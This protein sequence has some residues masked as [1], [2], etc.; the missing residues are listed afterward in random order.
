VSNLDFAFGNLF[1]YS[2]LGYFEGLKIAR[3]CT[4][5]HSQSGFNIDLKLGARLARATKKKHVVTV[6]QQIGS[7]HEDVQLTSKLLD[8]LLA[9]DHVVVNRRSSFK[10]LMDNGVGKIT[11]LYNPIPVEDFK[12]PE[13]MRSISPSKPRETVRCL[14]IGR[15][16]KRRGPELAL[17]GFENALGSGVDAELWIVGGGDLET[18]LRSYVSSRGLADSVKFFGDQSD[19]RGFLWNSDIFLATSEI[20]NSPSLALREAMASE[21]AI[22]ATDVEDTNTIIDKDETGL[23]VQPNEQSIGSAIEK[24]ASEEGIRKRLGIAAA[25]LVERKFDI[26]PYVEDLLRVYKKTLQG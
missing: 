8:L 9:A 11:L 14:Y 21:L 17:Q 3:N 1:T 20:A 23:L 24:L 26:R 4:L 15:L 10:H 12:K 6:H 13:N 22:V 5:I 19:V 25:E 16:V 7:R 18:S 2:K